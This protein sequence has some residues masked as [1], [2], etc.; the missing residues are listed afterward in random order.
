MNRETLTDVAG[1]SLHS[2]VHDELA[3]VLE[4]VTDTFLAIKK[5]ERI[6]LFIVEIREIKHK[7]DTNT[8]LIIGLVLDHGAWH[9]D[10]KK[11]VEDAYTLTYTCH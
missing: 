4:A 5:Q 3:D 7:S 1:T 6:D 9:P 2:K 8:C 11:G 10:V